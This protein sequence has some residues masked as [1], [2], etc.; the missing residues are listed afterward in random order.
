MRKAPHPWI[1]R[2]RIWDGH[3][4]SKPHSLHGVFEINGLVIMSSG[5]DP[6]Y[7]WEHVSVSRA[8]R[9]PTWAEMNS[10]KDLFWDEAEVVVQ[11][12]PAKKDYINQHPHCLHLWRPMRRTMPTPPTILVGTREPLEIPPNATSEPAPAAAHQQDPGAKAAG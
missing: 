4:G 8:D 2:Y 12:H 11:Y 9:D 1:E 7:G 6:K 10:I 5:P 3:Y